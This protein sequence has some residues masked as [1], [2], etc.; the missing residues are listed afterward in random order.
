MHRSQFPL[1]HRISPIPNS[2]SVLRGKAGVDLKVIGTELW[3]TEERGT[4]KDFDPKGSGPWH[5]SFDTIMTAL[6]RKLFEQVSQLLHH[7]LCFPSLSYSIGCHGNSRFIYSL[8]EIFEN[9]EKI[10][11]GMFFECEVWF[12]DLFLPFSFSV[13][14]FFFRRLITALLYKTYSDLR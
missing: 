2:Y 7:V 14:F 8:A 5:N 6:Q 3:P 11:T 13:S 9:F 1:F 12:S 4:Q 10:F